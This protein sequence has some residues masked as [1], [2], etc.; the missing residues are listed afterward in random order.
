M[1]RLFI[2]SF[3]FITCFFA[4]LCAQ[5]FQAGFSASTIGSGWS[6]PAGAA[7]NSAGTKLFVWEKGGRLYVCNWNGSSYVKQ[8]TAVLDISPEVGNWRDHGMLGFAL[9]PNFN[10]NGFIYLLYVVD[11]HHL[12]Y[13]GTGS[14][15]ATTNDYLKATIGRITRYKLITSGTNLVAD[16]TTRT[17]LVGETKSTGF[18]ILH[19]SHGIGS[20]AFAADGT[21]LATCGDGAS[22]NTTDAGNLAETYYVQ[23]LADGIIRSNENVGAFKSQM[24]NSLNG[25]LIR[26]DPATGNGISSN[27]FYTSA[28]PR[29]PQSRI[30]AMGF[31]NP[32]RF[33]VRPNT[34]S[35]NPSAGDIGEVYV[36]DVGWNTYEELNIVKSKAA[37]CGWPVFEGLTY[38]SS[39]NNT[40]TSNKDEPNPRYGIGGCTQQYFT[41]QN[42]IKQAT[43]DNIHT[44]YNPCNTSIPISSGNDNRFFHSV[45]S[46][47]WK[48]GVDSARVK[49]FNGNILNVAQIG[50]AASGTTGTPFRGNAASGSCWY[51]GTMFPLSYRNTY[52]QADYGGTWLKNFTIQYTDK[53]Q[54][55]NDFA[56][57]FAAIVCVTENPLDGSLVIVDL[58]LSAV[59]KIVYGGNQPP[60]AV[61]TSNKIFGPSPLAVNFTGSGSYDPDGSINSYSWDFGDGSALNTSSNPSHTFTY[62]S[63]PKKYVVKL[64]VRDN[65]NVATTDSLVISVNNTPPVVNITS[66]VKNSTYRL[67]A[68]TV[69]SCNA[70]VT[71]AEHTNGQLKY[72]WQSILRHNFHQHAEP[73]DTA[74][75]TSTVISRIGCNSET[76]YWF[77]KL[78]VTDAAGLSRIDSSKLFPACGGALPLILHSFAVSSQSDGNLVRWTT[79]S[80][81]KLDSFVVERSADGRNFIAIN[82]QIARG[83]G[84]TGQTEYNFFD[85]NYP[86]G[87]NY[88]RL[89]LVDKTRGYY[90]SLVI[91]VFNNLRR[92]RGLVV[93]PN[94]VVND[95]TLAGIFPNA[96]P[97]QIQIMDAEGR[98][99]RSLNEMAG[100]GFNNMLI[101]NL[102]HI[103]P[104]V[105]FIEVKDGQMIQR[106][107][108]IKL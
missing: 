38:M 59:K 63:G 67:G 69:Y 28:S 97:V 77:I 50:S 24:I 86:Q 35:T 79:E 56:S 37:N 29:S 106:T 82:R 2:S 66:P 78:T 55:V 30:W 62:A 15:S 47:D 87:D 64:T 45:P 11:R 73:I 54:K 102:R 48:H 19:E 80:E 53:V 74:R 76:Y 49:V 16:L 71:D 21:L 68:D 101:N 65:L 98:M 103:Q 32:F 81:I 14:Y 90:F 25:K 58:G 96:G 99:I 27:P 26:I 31:R 17:I 94:P 51:T 40:T 43:A 60:V 108:F 39:Y 23:A 8:T 9:D 34:G 83:S 105:Y 36:G 20:L 42:L 70:T 4:R 5:T 88:Y 104:G 18:P 22:Y 44:V 13:Y 95:F 92:E 52:F 10:T 6:E 41:F 57:G 85:V 91:R 93:I 107:K 12:I 1:K 61:M 7:F 100:S 46:I 89:K 33:C 72:Q 84:R 3:V 75:N